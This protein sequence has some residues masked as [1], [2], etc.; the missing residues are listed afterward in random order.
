MTISAEFDAVAA[1]AVAVFS[2]TINTDLSFSIFSSD[3]Y[4]SYIEMI[5]V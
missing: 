3:F 1:V 4:S 2:F 5:I